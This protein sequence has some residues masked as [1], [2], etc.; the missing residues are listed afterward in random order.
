MSGSRI[1]KLANF[2]LAVLIVAILWPGA[3]AALIQEVRADR[4][5]MTSATQNNDSDTEG[6]KKKK[7]KRKSKKK[8]RK[9][10]KK[11]KKKIRWGQKRNESDEKYDKR[12]KRLLKRIK[13]DKAGDYRGGRFEDESGNEIRL[14]T[15][16][17]HPGCPFIIRSDISKEFTAHLAMYMEMLHREFSTAYRILLG[18]PADVKEPVEIITFADRGTYMKAGGLPSSG[19]QFGFA[20]HFANDRGQSW[21]ARHYRMMQFTRGITDFAKWPKGVL[22]H[23]SCHMELYL[24]VGY[25]LDPTGTIG[26]PIIPP[27]WWNEGQAGVFENWDFRKT[28]DEN[29]DEIPNRGRYAPMI[30]RMFDTKDWKDFD[31]YWTINR[32]KW[33]SEGRVLKNYAQGWSICAYMMTGGLKGR[34]DFRRIFDLTKRVGTN[35]PDISFSDRKI[36]FSR[37]WA[38]VFPE[39]AQAKL[40][41]NWEGWVQEHLPKDGE[42]VVDEEFNL[43][44]HGYDPDTTARLQ[45]ITDE[46]KQ[47]ENDEWVKKEEKRRKKGKM[48]EW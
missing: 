19:G 20:M 14:W 15:H 23:E 40:S 31:Y 41:K 1:F 24:R 32:G 42:S 18:F 27:I 10:R 25:K 36:Q 45:P 38:E 13:Q 3:A 2:V 8:K 4:S 43:R 46:K 47:K 21:P 26:F 11:G 17:G 16:M 33:D 34:N 35:N 30:R 37:A 48:I 12:F 6:R 9:K 22:K 44:S 39:E 5:V 7:K 28:V 29:F